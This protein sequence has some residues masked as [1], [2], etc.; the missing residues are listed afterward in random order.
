MTELI[1]N[2][3]LDK[4]IIQ[5]APILLGGGYRLFEALNQQTQF[6]LVSVVKMGQYTEMTLV[7]K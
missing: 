4:M 3:Q 6:E 7:K 5:V 1:A 2:Q